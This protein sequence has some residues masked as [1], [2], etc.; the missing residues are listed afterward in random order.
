M[1]LGSDG[2]QHHKKDYSE[3]IPPKKSQ[4]ESDQVSRSDFYLTGNT[5]DR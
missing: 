2:H 5:G 3:E 1:D 4:P